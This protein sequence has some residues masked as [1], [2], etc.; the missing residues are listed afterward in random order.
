MHQIKKIFKKLTT[1]KQ[2]TKAPKQPYLLPGVTRVDLVTAAIGHEID[3]EVDVLL[4]N[5]I[6]QS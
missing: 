1:E 3:W 6:K 4:R 2:Q 5:N